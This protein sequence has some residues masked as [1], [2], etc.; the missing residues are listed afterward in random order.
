MLV[1]V[2]ILI[3]FWALSVPEPFCKENQSHR[4]TV[5]IKEAM[6]FEK[7]NISFIYVNG[8]SMLP[9]I[10]DGSVCVC[11]KKKDYLVGD[12]VVFPFVK[13]NYIVGI[14][15]RINSLENG[16][17]I[18]KGDNNQRTDLPISQEEIFCYVPEIPF[19]LKFFF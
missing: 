16:T 2:G 9:A 19:Y 15:H 17:I 10:E 18:T 13:D 11:A 6:A 12:V 7:S 1:L 8:T 3:L 14:V 4:I 5:E